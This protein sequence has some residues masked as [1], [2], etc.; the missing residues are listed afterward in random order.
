VIPANG[1]VDIADVSATLSGEGYL[2]VQSNGDEPFALIV[3]GTKQVPGLRETYSGTFASVAPGAVNKLYIRA[4]DDLTAQIVVEDRLGNLKSTTNSSFVAGSLS[5]SAVSI[6][7]GDTIK[8]TFNGNGSALLLSDGEGYPLQE[9]TQAM[10]TP[11][12]QQTIS[13]FPAPYVKALRSTSEV[14][15]EQ[16]NAAEDIASAFNASAST[17]ANASVR[18]TNGGKLKPVKNSSGKTIGLGY[19]LVGKNG[20]V[21]NGTV[22]K[23][24]QAELNGYNAV[25]SA[26]IASNETTPPAS[27]RTWFAFGDVEVLGMEGTSTQ[28]TVNSSVKTFVGPNLSRTLKL[29]TLA[30]SEVYKLETNGRLLLTGDAVRANFLDGD[31][32]EFLPLDGQTCVGISTGEPFVVDSY[33]DNGRQLGSVILTFSSGYEKRTLA[34]MAIPSGARSLRT[35]GKVHF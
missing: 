3:N 12:A 2:D 35:T 30:P 26:A 1:R 6:G 9:Y 13:S 17:F 18:E 22:K 14:R 11:A 27:P 29:T 25:L 8:V 23:D 24:R 4:D 5:E 20:S 31:R 19:V 10:L 21:F 15:W 34:E 32:V 16:Q 28:V 7:K 33:D